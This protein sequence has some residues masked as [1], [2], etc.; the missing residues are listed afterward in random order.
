M[1]TYLPAETKAQR[2]G[3][4]LAEPAEGERRI[5]LSATVGLASPSSATKTAAQEQWSGRATTCL[6]HHEGKDETPHHLSIIRLSATAS[7]VERESER[8]TL[9]TG[10]TD[11]TDPWRW[12]KKTSWV[13]PALGPAFEMSPSPKDSGSP[14]TDPSTPAP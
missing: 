6:P 4:R 9:A 1:T 7:A 13:H 14:E 3:R 2:L 10:S 8:T 12:K 11:S 5:R